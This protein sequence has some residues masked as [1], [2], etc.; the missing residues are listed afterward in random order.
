MLAWLSGGVTHIEI[1]RKLFITV[2]TVAHHI[3]TMEERFGVENRAAL[4]A[5]A[6]VAGILDAQWW[7]PSPT[8]NLCTRIPTTKCDEKA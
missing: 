8:G 7:P 5:A 1:A 3:T 4:V 2:H 6:F